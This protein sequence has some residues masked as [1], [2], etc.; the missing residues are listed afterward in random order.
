MDVTFCFLSTDNPLAWQSQEDSESEEDATAAKRKRHLFEAASDSD[1]ITDDVAKYRLIDLAL[2]SITCTVCDVSSGVAEEEVV[3]GFTSRFIVRCHVCS[4]ILANFPSSRKQEKLYDVNKRMVLAMRA[5]GLGYSGVQKL[6]RDLNMPCMSSNTFA[7]YHRSVKRGVKVCSEEWK[8]EVGAIVRSAYEEADPQNVGKDIID[9]SVSYD[10]TWQKRGFSSHNGVAVVID[11]LTGLVL[12]YCVLSNFCEKCVKEQNAQSEEEF[13]VW[14][15][16]HKDIGQCE[17]NFDGSAGAMEV[18]AAGV[19]WNRSIDLH[20]F[21]YTTMLSDG[22]CKSHK[23]LVYSEVYGETKVVKTDCVNHIAKRMGTAL[24]NL[25]K[26]TS[27]IGE[28]GRLT[29]ARI[30]KMTGYYHNAITSNF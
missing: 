25:K 24:R 30:V 26:Q 29:E 18:H 28:R 15:Y 17:Q 6:C 1:D 27:G 10:G 3:S 20:K 13:E 12:D 14:Q 7:R 23:H 5:N 9:I 11:C 4:A 19:L 8:K 21:R 16:I 22:D 2:M